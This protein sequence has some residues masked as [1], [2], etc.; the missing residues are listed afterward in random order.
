MYA[1]SMPTNNTV[2]KLYYHTF[3]P[4]VFEHKNPVGK[5]ADDEM[6]WS[7]SVTGVKPLSV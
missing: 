5:R 4:H 3:V 1:K 6:A 2:C 7:V